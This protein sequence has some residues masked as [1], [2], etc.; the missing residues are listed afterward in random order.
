[1]VLSHSA[2]V[3]R[4]EEMMMAVVVEGTTGEGKKETGELVGGG[5]DPLSR[6]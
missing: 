3:G 4:A 2:A 6:A 5:E 1:M